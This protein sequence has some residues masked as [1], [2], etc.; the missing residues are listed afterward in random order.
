MPM[1]CETFWKQ[2]QVLT[3]SVTL[4]APLLAF[5][6][7]IAKFHPRNTRDKSSA[8]FRCP[9]HLLFQSAIVIITHDKLRAQSRKSA[10]QESAQ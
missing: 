4:D 10:N 7:R 8:N 3:L 6:A 1:H 5:L 9:P 2:K